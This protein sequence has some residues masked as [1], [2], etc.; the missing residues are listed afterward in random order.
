MV[1]INQVKHV[2]NYHVLLLDL[3]RKLIHLFENLKIEAYKLL[4]C[5]GAV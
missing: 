3:V 2:G 5:S 4:D 1:A